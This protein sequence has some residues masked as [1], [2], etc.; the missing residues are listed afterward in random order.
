MNLRPYQQQYIDSVLSLRKKFS[1]LLLVAPTGSGKTRLSAA[2]ISDF[3]SEG[4]RVLFVVDMV[5]LIDQSYASFRQYDLK[6]GFIKAGYPSNAK[7]PVQIASVQTLASRSN[8]REQN[9][10]VV[11][12]DEAHVSVW[13]KAAQDVL[14]QYPNAL[15]LGLTATPYATSKKRRLGLIFEKLIWHVTPKQLQEQGFLVPLSY[16]GIGEPDL[17]GVRTQQYDYA[18][19]DLSAACDKP[20]TIESAVDSWF[21]IAAGRPT[22]VFCIDRKH[23]AH[24][25]KSFQNRQITAEIVTGETDIKERNAIFEKFRAKEITVIVS[26]DCISKGF[27]EPSA[28]VGLLMRPTKSKNLCHQ[29]IGR[30]TR[31]SK[32]KSSGLI[33]DQAGN[34]KRHGFIESVKSYV[35]PTLDDDGEET[36]APMKQCPE[37]KRLLYGFQ[38]VCE[39]GYQ[40]VTE[41]KETEVKS[42]K[43][44][45]IS[46]SEKR[47]YE[48]YRDMIRRAFENGYKPGWAYVQFKREFNKFPKFDYALGAIYSGVVSEANVKEYYEKLKGNNPAD[49][50]K[51]LTA[52]FGKGWQEYLKSTPS[53]FISAIESSFVRSFAKTVCQIQI[54]GE[55][56]SIK[57]KK[58]GFEKFLES[59]QGE[60]ARAAKKIGLKLA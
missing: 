59:K 1:K 14:E 3:I 6:C 58:S 39:C 50:K 52:E 37:C 38:M 45:F 27:D 29:Q 23:A 20:E 53:D 24:V 31:I 60:L 19:E 35:L 9:F 48:F 18:K 47:E 44:L 15:H 36:P 28:E 7:A 57:V 51:T 55:L 22:L 40:F 17:K 34:L 2:L 25:L 4:K 26:V 11:I 10:D 56:V 8:W 32:G 30:I 16:Y 13:Y 49:I 5:S 43:K 42:V 41:V 54:E 46:D 33:L 12:Y 21:Q